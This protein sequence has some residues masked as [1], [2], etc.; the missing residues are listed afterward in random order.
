MART[1]DVSDDFL[2]K[3]LAREYRN[4]RIHQRLISEVLSVQFA[5]Q[6]RESCGAVYFSVSPYMGEAHTLIIT[7][8]SADQAGKVQSAISHELFDAET[9]QFKPSGRFGG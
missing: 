1:T 8:Y 6:L 2:V 4:E 7:L 3:T 5:D 9:G